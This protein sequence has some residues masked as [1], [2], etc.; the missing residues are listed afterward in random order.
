MNKAF[1]RENAAGREAN[2]PDRAIS[3]HPNLVT[4]EGLAQ[5][6]AAIAWGDRRTGPRQ[7]RGCRCG[8]GQRYARSARLECKESH[9]TANGAKAKLAGAQKSRWVDGRCKH[10]R[11]LYPR[12]LIGRFGEHSQA[13]ASAALH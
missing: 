7:D 13:H 2:L 1:T 9:R 11:E 12:N 4:A 6:E 8:C 3:P 5:I 10:R